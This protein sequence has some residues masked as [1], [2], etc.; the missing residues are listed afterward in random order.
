MELDLLESLPRNEW[1]QVNV[2]CQTALYA[3]VLI[4]IVN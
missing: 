4:Q 3:T 2:F 1:T